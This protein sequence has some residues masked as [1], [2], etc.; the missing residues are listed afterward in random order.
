MKYVSSSNY[1]FGTP[2]VRFLNSK[3]WH[4]DWW[5]IGHVI[6]RNLLTC[7]HIIEY[8]LTLPHHLKKCC[9]RKTK[10]R[11]R[12]WK[13]KK[14]GGCWPLEIVQT[15]QGLWGWFVAKLMAGRPQ[16]PLIF[17][18]VFIIY[19]FIDVA[20]LT[21]VDLMIFTWVDKLLSVTWPST[22]KSPFTVKRT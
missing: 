15:P 6:A 7:V 11:R 19:F 5:P 2:A 1:S 9:I 21:G 4:S 3:Q 17:I 22:Y 13:E 8:Q 10:K 18:F 20:K 14:K 16:P 12:K